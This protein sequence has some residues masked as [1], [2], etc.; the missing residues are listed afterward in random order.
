MRR[1]LRSQRKTPGRRAP[2]PTGDDARSAKEEAS[3]TKPDVRAT[4]G[5]CPR[6]ENPKRVPSV[7]SR[8]A[9]HSVQGARP[10]RGPRTAVERGAGNPRKATGRVTGTDLRRGEHSEGG[11]QTRLT[12]IPG[13]QVGPACATLARV[14]ARR[15]TVRLRRTRR[16]D[17]DRPMPAVSRTSGE[18]SRASHPA[19]T[20]NDADSQD[21]PYWPGNPSVRAH[22][23]SG[24][25]RSE[26][27]SAFR[28]T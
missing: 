10:W 18:P 6:G 16:S 24:A 4:R 9:R 14:E 12:G 1:P 15:T 11:H 23:S 3:G 26:R 2:P 27:D 28:C 8:T 17:P 21:G 5:A 20:W 7:P 25:T 22:A 19:R 13:G